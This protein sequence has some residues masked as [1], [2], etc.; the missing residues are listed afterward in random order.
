MEPMDI[1]DEQKEEKPKGA[2]PPFRKNPRAWSVLAGL[3]V[4]LAGC[5]LFLQKM[6]YPIPWW[7]FTWPMVLI[8]LGAFILLKSGFRQ[9]GPFFLIA[10]GALFLCQEV[11]VGFQIERFIW[12]A[13]IILIGLGFI[14]GRHRKCNH[15]G[16][17]GNP[18]F[19]RRMQERMQ[20]K[21]G[22]E[23][24]QK[25]DQMRRDRHSHSWKD[26]EN[27]WRGSRYNP[28]TTT[29]AGEVLDINAVFGSV[30]RTVLSKN[31]AGGEVNAVL[32][33]CEVDFTKADFAGRVVLEV[34]AVLG[35]IRIIV[36]P[37][38]TVISEMDSVFG[39]LDDNRPTQLLHPDPEKVLI[40]EGA[41]V[42]GGTEV[43]VG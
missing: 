22:P 28:G 41:S 4:V 8:A 16:G 14:F 35:G 43:S 20:R 27:S 17:P 36:P 32:G 21:W 31:F 39:S 29:A 38:W 42:F 15:W 5:A 2:E 40:L 34:N 9:F 18:H 10:I 11:F 37:N 6:G 25:F 12:P 26:F 33:G 23:W 30:K 24:Q 3:V 19:R 7:L 1:K 13:V